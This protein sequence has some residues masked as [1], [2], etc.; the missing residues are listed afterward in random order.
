MQDQDK[1]L[2]LLDAFALIY[3]AYFSFIR[4]PLINSK[5]QDVSATT[6]YVNILYDLL[7]NQGATHL[8]VVFDPPGG[9]ISTQ[10]I[11]VLQ[12][13]SG[14]NARRYSQRIA[15][16]QEHHQSLQCTD[17]GSEEF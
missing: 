8:A 14:R 9:N 15:V 12:S 11:S 17:V 4:N 3:R 7:S 6:G 5:G 2:F 13:Q 16:Y 10:G 1:R